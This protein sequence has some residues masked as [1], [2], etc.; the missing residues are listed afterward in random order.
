MVM[1]R[2]SARHAGRLLAPKLKVVRLRR[3]APKAIEKA[4]EVPAAWA[5]EAAEPGKQLVSRQAGREDLDTCSLTDET[6]L[7]ASDL[8]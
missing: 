8:H 3:I 6:P 4:S 7:S 5:P 2:K 1:K